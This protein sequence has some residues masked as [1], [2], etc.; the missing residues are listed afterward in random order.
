MR[1][2]LLNWEV[3]TSCQVFCCINRLLPPPKQFLYH[4]LS[5]PNFFCSC[6][7][8]RNTPTPPYKNTFFKSGKVPVIFSGF[9]ACSQIAKR[10]YYLRHVRPSI[11]LPACLSVRMVHFGFQWT[12]FN[13]IYI[14]DFFENMLRKFTS[15]IKIL[16]K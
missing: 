6:Q 14:S 15:F 4:F 10:D 1:K 13:K 2:I 9:Q 8:P 7:F 12:D 5:A 3:T 11:C 16:R